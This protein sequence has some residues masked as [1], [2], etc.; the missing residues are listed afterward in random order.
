M[1]N[2]FDDDEGVFLVLRNDELQYSLW[3]QQIA[4]PGG[5]AV[6]FGPDSRRACLDH[7][8]KHWVDLRPRSL[9]EA[10]EGV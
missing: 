8:E 1:S 2:P 5:W 4:V 10:T 7:V 9:I 3:P 6:V